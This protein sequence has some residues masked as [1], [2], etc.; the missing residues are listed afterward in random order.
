MGASSWARSQARGWPRWCANNSWASRRSTPSWRAW[1]SA[2]ATVANSGTQR[3]LAALQR[4]QLLGRARGL[5][6]R[7]HV[8]EVAVHHG[9]ELVQREVDAVIGQPSLRKVVGADAVGAVAAA[10]QALARGGFL[11][12]AL[13]LF[14]VAQARRQNGHRLGLVAVL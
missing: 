8:V 2:S 10:D 9:A 3:T 11:G 6:C 7:E 1:A 4:R 13:A 5:Q 14:L 12:R